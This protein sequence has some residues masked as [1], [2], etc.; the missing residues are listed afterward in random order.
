M[1]QLKPVNILQQTRFDHKMT[2]HFV[3]IQIIIDEHPDINGKA[4][5]SE[6]EN[7]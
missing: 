2:M 3:S 5:N 4:E 6:L 7:V 1:R